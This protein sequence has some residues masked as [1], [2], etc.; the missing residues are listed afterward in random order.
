MKSKSP[1]PA[2]VNLRESLAVFMSNIVVLLH[3]VKEVEMIAAL[4]HLSPPVE[5]TDKPI[6]WLQDNVS[7]TLGIFGDHK[8]AL[9]QT[10]EGADCQYELI[11]ALR[12]LPNAKLIITL[13]YA[14]G[15]KSKCKLGD[16]LVSTSIDGIGNCQLQHGRLKFDEGHVRQT[17]MSTR[18]L[19][20]FANGNMLWTEFICSK[21]GR[22]TKVLSGPQISSPML[23]SDKTA[24]DEYLKTNEQFNGGETEGQEVANAQ[25]FLKGNDH[26]EVDFVVIKGVANFGDET[27]VK[28]WQLTASLAAAFYAEEKICESCGNVYN[29]KLF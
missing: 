13:G 23:F 7:L 27:K 29:C 9:V 1:I 26:R 8:A 17:S 2:P 22:K 20:V 25:L 18:A 24:L 5:Q 4:K 6:R 15:L 10:K 21:E 14:Y 28:E 12:S 19:N 3:T 11:P 16:V